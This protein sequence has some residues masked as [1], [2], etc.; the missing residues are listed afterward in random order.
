MLNGRPQHSVFLFLSLSLIN[1]PKRNYSCQQPI[2]T[3][4]DR[5]IMQSC[6]ATSIMLQHFLTDRGQCETLDYNSENLVR[7]I[8]QPDASFCISHLMP[9]LPI[10]NTIDFLLSL[11]ELL[12]YIYET[13]G[14]MN[15]HYKRYKQ[16]N[17]TEIL[18]NIILMVN[19]TIL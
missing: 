6:N 10:Y 9:Q 8:C 13:E 4:D 19:S 5:D 12:C 16:A 18:I 17:K 7:V 15:F 1:N 3:Q 2:T 14:Q 11:L